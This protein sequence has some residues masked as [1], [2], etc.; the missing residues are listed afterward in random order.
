M[1]IQIISNLRHEFGLYEL[2]F[3]TAI[4]LCEY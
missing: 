3:E 2:N 1:K 4:R